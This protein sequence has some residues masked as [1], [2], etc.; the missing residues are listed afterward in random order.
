MVL[1]AAASFLLAADVVA[2]SVALAGMGNIAFAPFI[3]LVMGAI[4]VC[5][6][7][8]AYSVLRLYRRETWCSCIVAGFLVG[9]GV[10]ALVLLP[11]PGSEQ[12]GQ[13]M[14]IVAG[15]R[16]AAGWRMYAEA[17][18]TAGG[19]GAGAGGVFWAA[20][21]LLERGAR[22]PR[23]G[24]VSLTGGI[25]LA[26]AASWTILALPSLTMDRSCHNVFRDGRR[27]IM[28][29]LFFTAELAG[30]E[31][32]RFQNTAERFA[33]AEGWTVDESNDKDKAFS[34]SRFVSACVE[35]GTR[36]MFD[37]ADR[38]NPTIAHVSVFQP[39]GDDGWRGPAE[40][41]LAAIEAD[42]PG[43]LR[44]DRTGTEVQTPSTLL[45][46]KR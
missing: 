44:R 33:S 24:C 22:S 1:Q 12:I 4:S 46:Q 3:L 34:A 8:P 11:V 38:S 18:G 27:S 2:V 29:V 42:F 9:A 32:P 45:P 35:P 13:D 26:I 28:P 36:I 21:R 31:W 5:L 6:A 17:V 40:R 43:R 37:G 20:L 14:T 30:G 39:Q 16:T 19:I 10:A 25:S 15:A 23:L 7:M 41:L